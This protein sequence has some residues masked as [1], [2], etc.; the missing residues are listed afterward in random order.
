MFPH[1][2]EGRFMVKALTVSL[3]LMFIVACG[4]GVPTLNDLTERDGV[5]VLTS[6]GQPYT[7]EVMS[8]Y[9]SGAPKLKASMI[10]GKP[11]GVWT[12]W[13]ENGQK[14]MEAHWKQGVRDGDLDRWYE[15]GQEQLHEEY[16]N[17][18]PR[19]VHKEWYESG[20]IKAQKPYVSGKPFGTW[21]FWLEDGHKEKNEI[22]E[23]GELVKTIER[24]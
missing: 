12:E 6:S 2:T 10:N 24:E 16:D 15:K 5:Y 17:G 22:Y 11:D 8:T 14:S 13:Y 20:Q 9:A 19:G 7:G 21:Q 3:L 18:V 23:N 1:P 4:S